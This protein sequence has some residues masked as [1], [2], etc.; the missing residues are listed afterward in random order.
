MLNRLILLTYHVSFG[1]KKQEYDLLQTTYDTFVFQQNKAPSHRVKDTIK[2]LQQETLDFIGPDLWPPNSQYLNAV[3]LL[4]AGV[5][6]S[7]EYMT[8]V[9]TVSMS[10]T[11]PRWSLEQSATE[12][13]WRG[14][15]V[16]INECRKRLRAWTKVW[17]FI[18]SRVTDKSWGQIKYK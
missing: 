16:A 17:T 11:A 10:W 13:Y 18:V 15:A 4:W 9:W 5:L 1:W 7:R 6:C 2:L 8:V 3:D 12:R 14:R